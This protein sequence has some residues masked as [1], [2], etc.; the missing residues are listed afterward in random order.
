MFMTHKFRDAET[1][2]E[3]VAKNRIE[4]VSRYIIQ[5]ATLSVNRR[6]HW[7]MPLSD[8]GIIEDATRV[9]FHENPSPDWEHIMD[10]CSTMVED[11]KE[12]TDDLAD[13]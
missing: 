4:M 6:V 1:K 2:V 7:K 11:Y 13:V 9:F 12:N 8:M 5:H 3:V 10:F